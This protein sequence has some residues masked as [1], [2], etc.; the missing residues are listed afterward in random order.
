MILIAVIIKYSQLLNS[1]NFN[2][3]AEY[4]AKWVPLQPV[5]INKSMLQT[6]H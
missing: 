4:Y 5:G 3:Y 1:I 6:D 2:T